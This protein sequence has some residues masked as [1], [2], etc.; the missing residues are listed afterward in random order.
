MYFDFLPLNTFGCRHSCTCV[1][2]VILCQ[3]FTWVLETKPGSLCLRVLQCEPSLQAPAWFPTPP[4]FSI[5][6][7]FS[8]LWL[9]DSEEELGFVHWFWPSVLEVLSVYSVH[10]ALLLTRG[11][12]AVVCEPGRTLLS[13]WKLGNKERVKERDLGQ[14]KILKVTQA[15]HFQQLGSRSSS[16]I[17]SLSWWSHLLIIIPPGRTKIS[18]YEPFWGHFLPEPSHPLCLFVCFSS[19]FQGNLSRLLKAVGRQRHEAQVFRV[20]TREMAS[21][22][23]YLPP[24]LTDRIWSLGCSWWKERTDSQKFPSALHTMLW[25]RHAH[26]NHKNTNA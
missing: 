9:H 3:A 4:W 16:P 2:R 10:T 11:E 22:K 18:L 12:A 6:P 26:R 5:D 20:R 7:C 8:F 24:S 14:Q 1:W 25:H 21:G 13:S 17:Q 19:S 15:H 23:W